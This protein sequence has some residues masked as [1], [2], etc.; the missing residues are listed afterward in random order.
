MA[1]A[2]IPITVV[3]L[4]GNAV[5]GATVTI[6]KRSDGTNAVLYLA[7]TGAPTTGNP[8][9]TNTQGRVPYWIDRGAYAATITGTGI[10]TYVENFEASPSKDGGIDTAWASAISASGGYSAG[11]LAARPTVPVYTKDTY[12]ATDDWG[13]TLYGAKADLSGWYTVNSKNEQSFLLS[14]AAGTYTISGL[15]GDT[16]EAYILDFMLLMSLVDNLQMRF[17][18]DT[19]ANYNNV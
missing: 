9:S 6:K 13:G 2:P 10:T 4:L 17:N 16:D 5:A 12:F 11:L 15:A 18:G 3:D 14:A 8:A 7:E 1:R 19:G